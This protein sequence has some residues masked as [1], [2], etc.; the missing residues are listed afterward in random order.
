LLLTAILLSLAIVNVS[1]L[2]DLSSTWILKVLYNLGG[3]ISITIDFG[4]FGYCFLSTVLN[5]SWLGNWFTHASSHASTHAKATWLE[6]RKSTSA[7]TSIMTHHAHASSEATSAEEIVVFKAHSAEWIIHAKRISTFAFA[8]ATSH[9]HWPES[10]SEE[11]IVFIKEISEWILASEELS[12]YFV[13]TSHI[14]VVEISTSTA[15]LLSAATS[16]IALDVVSSIIIVVLPLLSIAENA[17]GI[18]NLFEDFL[19]LLL[20]ALVLIWVVLQG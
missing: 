5:N 14:K 20:I 18:G 15:E 8:L 12:K 16:S 9:S 3:L 6:T 13:G 4:L 11:V 17:I 19:S 1:I 7:T 2:D 10:S